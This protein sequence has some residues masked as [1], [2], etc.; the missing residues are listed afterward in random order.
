MQ[1]Q[2]KGKQQQAEAKKDQEDAIE[3]TTVDPNYITKLEDARKWLLCLFF[4]YLL[5]SW[6]DYKRCLLYN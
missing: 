3:I 4:F 6:K 2:K 1:K 5:L